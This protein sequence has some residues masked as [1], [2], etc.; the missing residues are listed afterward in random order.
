M[1]KEKRGQL[2]GRWNWRLTIGS[3]LL[4]LS[5]PFATSCYK[6]RVVE[7][8][9]PAAKC[10]ISAI[11]E[12]PRVSFSRLDVQSEAGERRVMAMTTG[13]ELALLANWLT[14]MADWVGDVSEC[15]HL[16]VATSPSVK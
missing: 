4:L 9:V 11:P 14:T 1:R 3:A 6:V 15:P 12:F 7:K 13:E 10:H 8:P 5:L 2:T 16:A